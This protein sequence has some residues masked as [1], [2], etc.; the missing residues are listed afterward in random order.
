MSRR[1]KTGENKK[2]KEGR[3]SKRAK[4]SMKTHKGLPTEGQHRLGCAQW[5]A[6]E[7]QAGQDPVGRSGRNPP[8]SSILR[9]RTPHVNYQGTGLPPL[10]PEPGS[11]SELPSVSPAPADSPSSSSGRVFSEW[12]R[13]SSQ[14]HISNCQLLHPPFLRIK[15]FSLV[16]FSHSVMSD[17]L[18]P[19]GLQHARLPCPSPTPRAYS[20][21][22]PLSQWSHPTRSLRN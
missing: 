21:S 11:F 1:A 3:G 17:S 12:P 13:E 4:G 18:P 19:H 6:S 15:K 22:H 9:V 20:N 8:G 2:E 10:L 14:E 5:R 16:Q 7:H